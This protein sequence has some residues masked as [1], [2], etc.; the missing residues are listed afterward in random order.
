MAK[1]L[2]IDDS[3]TIRTLVQR[4]L[5]AAGHEVILAENGENG[6][7]T[8]IQHTP[9][10]VFT[11]LNMPGINGIDIMFQLRDYLPFVKIIVMS[12]DK[13]IDNT[14]FLKTTQ[15][16]DVEIIHKPF[17]PEEIQNAACSTVIMNTAS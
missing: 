3:K 1:V 9:D 12:S 7:A 13:R 10:I 4:Y 8:A 14:S 17:G 15:K 5:M 16:L 2:V 11:D 6:V